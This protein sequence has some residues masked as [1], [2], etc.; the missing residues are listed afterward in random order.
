ML[1]CPYLF[2]LRG[3]LRKFICIVGPSW[4]TNLCLYFYFVFFVFGTYFTHYC[5]VT[6][7]SHGGL[8][9]NDF[10]FYFYFVFCT[11]FLHYCAVTSYGEFPCVLIFYFW[12]LS[13]SIYCRILP[14]QLTIYARWVRYMHTPSPTYHFL[15]TL[16]L[17]V[18]LWE[19]N[20]ATISC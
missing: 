17:L 19:T 18:F 3:L 7:H 6:S 20:S 8:W 15:L 12:M 2:S 9:P 11:Y 14:H 16:F 5:A 4:S 1:F 13:P 10:C